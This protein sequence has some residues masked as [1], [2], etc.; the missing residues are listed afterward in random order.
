MSQ[1][2]TIPA[3]DGKDVVDDDGNKMSHGI[4][5]GVDQARNDALG[6]RRCADDEDAAPL[7][8]QCHEGILSPGH[9]LA[10]TGPQLQESTKL[11]STPGAPAG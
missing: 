2:K 10:L 7:Q 5:A 8:H 9:R 1:L 3:P 4:G 6:H 11:R